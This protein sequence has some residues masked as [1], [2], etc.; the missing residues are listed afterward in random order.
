MSVGGCS[1]PCRRTR[2]FFGCSPCFYSLTHLYWFISGLPTLLW[3]CLSIKIFLCVIFD[4]F[5]HQKHIQAED[6]GE[7]SCLALLSLWG[8]SRSWRICYQHFP[9]WEQSFC[10]GLFSACSQL[11][12][13]GRETS[14]FQ[15]HSPSFGSR[16]AAMRRCWDNQES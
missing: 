4:F 5:Y 7:Y 9:S 2:S 12:V 1:H 3:K 6:L 13:P 16:A 15:L 10:R 8:S 14:E 11:V